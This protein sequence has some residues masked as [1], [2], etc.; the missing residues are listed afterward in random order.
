MSLSMIIIILL[1]GFVFNVLPWLLALLSR[2]AN[3]SHKLIWF[4]MSFFISWLGY[5]VYYFL[6]IKPDWQKRNKR[7]KVPRTE[8]GI[9]IRHLGNEPNEH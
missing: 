7:F 6:V 3:G 8:T 9:P 4:L 2:K 5:F 1:F